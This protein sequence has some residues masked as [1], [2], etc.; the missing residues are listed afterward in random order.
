MPIVFYKMLDV[1]SSAIKDYSGFD[2]HGI[3]GADLSR[4]SDDP[5]LTG[6]GGI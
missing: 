2:Y 4:G 5:I 3:L 6:S 1:A